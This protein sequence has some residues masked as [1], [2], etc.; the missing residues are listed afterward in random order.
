MI[1]SNPL[2]SLSDCPG[3][4]SV[5][6]LQLIIGT[7]PFSYI[8]IPF[9]ITHCITVFLSCLM[10]HD[11]VSLTHSMPHVMCQLFLT[12]YQY[13]TS[14]LG[15]V[16][17][18]LGRTCSSQVYSRY[19]E[20]QRFPISFFLTCYH[21]LFSLFSFLVWSLRP[22]L[23]SQRS[24]RTMPFAY[25]VSCVRKKLPLAPRFGPKLGQC[26]TSVTSSV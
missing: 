2:L 5:H 4:K 26:S 8:I 19:N 22:R 20:D 17:Q 7:A 18:D 15:P 14:L 10:T 3:T 24:A 6:V 16:S 9:P 21:S 11:L 23:S 1:S 25:Q 12:Q 13:L